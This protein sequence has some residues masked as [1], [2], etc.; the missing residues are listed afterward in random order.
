VAELRRRYCVEPPDLAITDFDPSN[1]MSD[2]QNR[3]G[4]A[5]HLFGESVPF[6][7]NALVLGLQTTIRFERLQGLD[8]FRK[9]RRSFMQTVLFERS[10]VH[11]AARELQ[12]IA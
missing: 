8:P 7:F 6:G 10:V 11:L 9:L 3:L 12:V 2:P 1:R 4:H 5:L